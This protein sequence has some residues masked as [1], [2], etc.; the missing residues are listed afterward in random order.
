M[1][2]FVCQPLTCC[3]MSLLYACM[4]KVTC[5]VSLTHPCAKSRR[6]LSEI[7]RK[8]VRYFVAKNGWPNHKVN[9]QL[10]SGVP[11]HTHTPNREWIVGYKVQWRCAPIFPLFLAHSFVIIIMSSELFIYRACIGCCPFACRLSSHCYFNTIIYFQ[12]Y[13]LFYSWNWGKST[14]YF[15]PQCTLNF[16]DHV[17]TL[18]GVEH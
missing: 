7:L 15:S 18:T 16:Y 3:I 10:W 2:L 4:A 5:N 13:W 1:H 14:A 11:P 8:N 9:K 12:S 6:K 17:V